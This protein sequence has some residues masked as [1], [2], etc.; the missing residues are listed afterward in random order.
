MNEETGTPEGEVF[1][2]SR[3]ARAPL[4][5]VVAGTEERGRAPLPISPV[6]RPPAPPATAPSTPSQGSSSQ[7]GG[8]GS[9]GQ[10]GSK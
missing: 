7:S 9:S 3:N 10:A 6:S 2:L 5:L 4:P 8:S 1:L